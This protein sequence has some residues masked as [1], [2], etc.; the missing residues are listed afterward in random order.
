MFHCLHFST[1]VAIRI[2]AHLRFICLVVG[3]D[4]AIQDLKRC[5][6]SFGCYDGKS[7]CVKRIVEHSL[8]RADGY[9]VSY[10]S[11]VRRGNFD[12]RVQL[13]ATF[14]LIESTE[15]CV[16]VHESSKVGSGASIFVVEWLM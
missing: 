14:E 15:V 6:S 8:R 12:D 9:V 16:Q 4:R 5:F 2:Q 3:P 7:Q 11:P 10:S 1:A 13:F